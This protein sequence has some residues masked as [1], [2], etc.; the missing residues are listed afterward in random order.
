MRVAIFD[1]DGTL[2]PQ[3]TF[4]LMMNYMKKHPDHS[5]KYKM[6]Y[7][8]LMKPYLA[9]KMKIYPENKMKAK[10]MQLYINA[11]KG[12]NQQELDKYFED[13]SKGM[14]NELN[15]T[16][17]D[18]LQKHLLDGDHVLLVS[19]AFT[20]MLNEVTRDYAIHGVIGTEIPMCNGIIDTETAIYHIQGERKKEMIEKA[21]K[22]MDIDWENSSAYG[23]SISDISVLEL[24]GN[25]V[26]VRP[27]SRLKVV[28]E[29]R[30]WEIIW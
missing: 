16:V 15:R 23:D 10:S 26:A 24:V 2:Y 14:R 20:Q 25:P 17:V 28:A 7:R 12:M 29:K 3:E 5:S 19:G 6:F 1:F 22:G 8:A 18:R 30:K 13:M 9:Y 27:E 4:T 21:L 11:I